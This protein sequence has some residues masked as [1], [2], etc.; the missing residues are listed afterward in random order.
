MSENLAGVRNSDRADS[1]VENGNQSGFERGERKILEYESS[2][3]V[4]DGTCSKLNE[5]KAERIHSLTEVVYDKDVDGEQHCA[6]D[7]KK[8][9]LSQS[10]LGAAETEQ[11]QADN[12]EARAYPDLQSRLFSEEYADYGNENHIQSRDEPALSSRVRESNADL[13]NVRCGEESNTRHKSGYE[14]GF[15]ICLSCA[16]SRI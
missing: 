16:L 10:K 14:R 9:T 4:E 3:A 2:Y 11:E 15:I 13:L 6:E 1:A 7:E 5:G 12:A 8:I